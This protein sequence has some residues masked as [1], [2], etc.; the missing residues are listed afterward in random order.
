M[1]LAMELTPTRIDKHSLTEMLLEWS[2]GKRYSLAFV[3]LRFRC[4]CAACV[5]EHTGQRVIK[6]ESISPEIRPT[7]VQLVGRYAVQIT[8]TDG[9]ST[10]MFHY[11]TLAKLCEKYGILIE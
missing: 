1:L 6:K 7:N 2:T 8:W 9:H 3:E 10:G 11:D 4:P 5:D